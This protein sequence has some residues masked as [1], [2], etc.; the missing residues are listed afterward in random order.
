MKR[1]S[2]ILAIAALGLSSCKKF[3]DTKPTDT[4][5]PVNY[6]T[7]SAQLQQ[8]LNSAY[9]TLMRQ[10]LYGQVLGFNFTASNDELLST[11][12]TDGDAR[13]LRF[14]FDATN[15]YVGNL[16]SYCY[17]GIGNLNELLDNIN[18]PVDSTN[19]NI[20]KG[21]A[22]F[23]R[24]YYYFLLTMHFGDVPLVLH[25]PA[26]TDVNIP[27]TKQADIYAQIE[28]DMKQAETLLQGYTLSKLGYSDV[29]SLDA[30]Q[31]VLSR[32]YIYWAGFPQ[33]NTTKYN[34]A[35]T[36]ANKVV[37]SGLHSLNPDYRQVFINLCQ[38]KYDIK[39]S[40]WELG[41]YSAAQGTNVKTG[42]DIGNF[43]GISSSY[44]ASDTTSFGGAGWVYTT[45]KLYDIYGVDATSTVVP[46]S[47]FDIRRDW[48]CASY[49]YTGSPRAKKAYNLVWENYSGK[50]N[51][52]YCPLI[53]KANGIY[54][55][56][57]P[58]IR[59]SDVLLMKA[60]AENQVNGPTAAAYDAINQVRR[61]GYGILNGNVV[62]SIK[63]TFGGT[64][65]T[66]APT[67]TFTG[68]GGSGATGTAVISNG[69]VTGISL[70]NPGNLTTVGPYYTS[71]PTIVISGGGGTG[72]MATATI[73]A[74]TDADLA[75]GLSKSDFQLA[76]RDE[77]MKELNAEGLR[78]FD[79]I[80]WGNYVNDI[81]N[82]AVYAAAN[83]VQ[84]SNANP[85]GYQGLLNITQKN[86]LLPIPVYELNLD[87]ALVQNPG[88]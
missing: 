55:I 81:Q 63:I 20:I 66:T 15:A 43:V 87:H 76:I 11:R 65:Y 68:G 35:L 31:A 21:Q 41:S 29:V 22:L 44:V 42:N 38:D 6:Y 33:N 82:F 47:S 10:N 69:V 83:G 45:K 8:A 77:R 62:K 86:V 5:T 58:V 7:T 46:Q 26:I 30:V 34:D 71:A 40:I 3:L 19:R 48:N 75:S 2:F 18:K 50:F 49:Y 13:G 64:G 85:N 72:A 78:R 73:T 17:I 16:Y 67:V 39:E 4:Y 59:Y 61:R 37:N 54:G 84:A 56:N 23:L 70:T 27:Q 88:W 28:S 60:E 57:W 74:A 1:I 14:N 24:G 12:T 80:R 25:V 36:Y 32:V 53:S 52:S 51:R 79:L 9:S